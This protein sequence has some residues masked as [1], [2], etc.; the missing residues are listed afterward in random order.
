MMRILLFPPPFPLRLVLVLLLPSSSSSDDSGE[1]KD[2][3]AF[4]VSVPSRSRSTGATGIDSA[5]DLLPF[6]FPPSS[7]HF[8]L[9]GAV[10]TPRSAASVSK[11]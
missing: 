1:R 2:L 9:L 8:R 10:P 11:W 5:L 3:S 6:R 4:S 7:V